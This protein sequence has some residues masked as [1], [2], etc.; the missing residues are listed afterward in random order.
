VVTIVFTPGVTPIT[1]SSNEIR[2][3]S[4]NYAKAVVH[5]KST[6]ERIMET[7]RK[8]ILI[9]DDDEQVLIDLER[10]LEDQGYGTTTAWSGQEALQ[11]LHTKPFDFVLLDHDLADLTREDLMRQAEQFCKTHWIM[12]RPQA[13]F[14]SESSSAN[15]VCK[16]E[17]SAILSK[18]RECLAG[19]EHVS[20]AKRKGHVA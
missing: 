14:R 11:L 5:S 7:Q 2:Y 4:R 17:H 12:L 10:L 16:W 15:S 18:L 19:P 6:G 20:G 8:T 13:R 9:V 1:V 3:S